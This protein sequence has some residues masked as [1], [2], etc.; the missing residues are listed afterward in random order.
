MDAKTTDTST[1]DEAAGEPALPNIAPLSP[2]LD[3]A[4]E[5]GLTELLAKV[6]PLIQGKRFDNVVDLLSL[7]SDGVDMFDDAMVQKLMKGYEEVIGGV[8]GLGNAARFAAA[9]TSASAPPSLFGLLRMAGQEDVRRGLA[10]ALTFLA[11][12]GRQMR[13]EDQ[14]AA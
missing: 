12:L 11:V 9:Q 6:T 5:K 3:E 7:V 13:K 1:K 2:L 10:F 4:T 8:W 14:D